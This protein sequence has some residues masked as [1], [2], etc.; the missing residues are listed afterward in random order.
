MEEP[1]LERRRIGEDGDGGSVRTPW[2]ETRVFRDS[3]ICLN[4]KES[5]QRHACS[6]C[7]LYDDVPQA[8]R[9]EDI[10][11]HHIPLTK[12]GETISALAER[13]PEAAERAL[14]EWIDATLARLEAAG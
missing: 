9:E 8:H 13:D 1:K 6:D 3:P 5:V 10:P 4:Y 7:F 11:C 14:V 12:E 2:Q